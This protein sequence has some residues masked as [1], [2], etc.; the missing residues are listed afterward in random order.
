MYH[1]AGNNPIRYTDPDGRAYTKKVCVDARKN[2]LRY[3]Y[4]FRATDKIEQ[5]LETVTASKI[6]F[7]GTEAMKFSHYI[8]DERLIEEGEETI[9]FLSITIDAL[10]PLSDLKL[11]KL[12][13]RIGF[14]ATWIG[15]IKTGKE[16][17][18]IFNDNDRFLI[19]E[20][21][22]LP[23]QR[24]LSSTSHENVSALYMYAKLVIKDMLANGDIIRATDKKTGDKWT[25]TN[26]SAFNQLKEDL[27]LLRSKLEENSFE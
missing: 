14:V 9:D 27:L 3:K 19:E 4:Y 5:S 7:V 10:S 13:A 11:S 1:Y 26:E 17:F 21:C 25:I 15:N 2:H 16:L 6:P 18:D 12:S 20:I 22:S 23:L 8:N 24:Y